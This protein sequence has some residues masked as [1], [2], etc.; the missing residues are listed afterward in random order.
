VNQGAGDM[1]AEAQ[2]PKNQNDYE[3]CPKH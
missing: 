1:K 3:N 2:Q